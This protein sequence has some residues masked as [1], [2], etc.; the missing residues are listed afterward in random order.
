MAEIR[1]P[2]GKTSLIFSPID[3]HQFEL[4]KPTFTPPAE[5]PIENVRT[6]IKQPLNGS[7]LQPFHKAKTVAIAINDKTRP[8]P[9]QHLLPPLLDELARIGIKKESIFF[10]ISVGTHTPM[11][12]SEFSRILPEEIIKNY[13]VIS[14]NC[15]DESS[16]IN[17]GKSSRGTIIQIN[18]MFYDSDLKIVVGNIEPHHFSG[19]SGGYKTAVIGLGSRKMINQNHK[20]LMDDRARIAEFDQ[21][22]LRQ[23]IEEIGKILNV[24]FALNSVLNNEKSIV[25]TFFGDPSDVMKMAIPVSTKICQTRAEKKADLV[26]ASVG[27]NPKD[28]NLYQSQK[29]LSHASLLTK[30][31][32]VVVLIAACPEGSGS[33][34]H[35]EFMQGI[36]TPQ[37]AM[38]K[39]RSIEFRVGP[40]KAFQFS[41]ELFRIHV[42]LISEMNPD[43]VKQLLLVPAANIKEA[44]SIAKKWLPDEYTIALMPYATNTIPLLKLD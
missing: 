40:H 27:G 29:A 35:E 3:G 44:V 38:E 9:N 17:L 15:D 32:G 22:P 42:I 19:F 26:I 36:A 37:Q 18:R 41:R 30:D 10:I 25:S 13:R 7:S 23:D 24:Q 2:Y 20:M 11:E 4:V 14:H 8:V 43:L 39:F 5:D 33:R 21:N 6:A 16:L 1:F 34:F 12:H 31:G 28:I